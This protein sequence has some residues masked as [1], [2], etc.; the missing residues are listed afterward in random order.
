MAH[1]RSKKIKI[2]LSKIGLETFW[3]NHAHFFGHNATLYNNTILHIGFAIFGSLHTSTFFA[4]WFARVFLPI[5][6]H[7]CTCTSLHGYLQDLHQ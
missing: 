2:K 3:K 5:I 7:Y 6:A 1:N 4:C